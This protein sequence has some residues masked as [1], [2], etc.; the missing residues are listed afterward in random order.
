MLWQNFEQFSPVVFNETTM[1]II[2][3]MVTQENIAFRAKAR[4]R[5]DILPKNDMSPNTLALLQK[6]VRVFSEFNSSMPILPSYQHVSSVFVCIEHLLTHFV[7]QIHKTYLI[8][9]FAALS[10]KNNTFHE[11]RALRNAVTTKWEKLWQ[12]VSHL[13]KTMNF[14]RDNVRLLWVFKRM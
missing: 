9:K 8:I 1:R 13:R 6:Y 5:N 2:P 3:I 7:S 12:N 10:F 4:Y 14:T 11:M